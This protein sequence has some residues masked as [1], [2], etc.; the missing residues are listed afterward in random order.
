[1]VNDDHIP[2]KCF[3][4]LYFDHDVF[5]DEDPKFLLNPQYQSCQNLVDLSSSTFISI[6]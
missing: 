4:T 6:G 1:M 5:H 2:Q 3:L